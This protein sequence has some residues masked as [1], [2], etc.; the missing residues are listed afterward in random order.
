MMDSIKSYGGRID[1]IYVC[2]DSDS[3]SKMLKPGIGMAEQ[4][5]EDY[6]D[7][8][9]SK[10]VM[11]GDTAVDMIFAKRIGAEFVNIAY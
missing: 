6:A 4:I 5:K 11:V 8:D 3:H 7:F 2:G 1:G 10:S 9:F